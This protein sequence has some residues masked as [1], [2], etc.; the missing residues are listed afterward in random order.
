MHACMYAHA[1]THA[2]IHTYIHA[3]YG[4]ADPITELLSTCADQTRNAAGPAGAELLCSSDAKDQ[5][6]QKS[7]YPCLLSVCLGPAGAEPLPMRRMPLRGNGILRIGCRED[8]SDPPLL[9]LLIPRI[10]SLFTCACLPG[11]Q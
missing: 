9:I 10:R 7:V 5:K 1:C 11:C 3:P 6:N 2:R 8:S 4:E